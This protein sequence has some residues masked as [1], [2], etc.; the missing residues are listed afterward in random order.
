[1]SQ[2][3][4]LLGDNRQILDSLPA[5]SAD[6]CVCDP[7]Y[8]II[9][10]G[11][12]FAIEGAGKPWETDLTAME[13]E[14]WKKI[15]RVLKPGAHL[16]AFCG[17][18]FYHLMG[19]AIHTAGFQI[20]DQIDWIYA[21]GMPRNKNLFK[22]AHEVIC[23]ARKP[24]KPKQRI[25][26]NTADAAIPRPAHEPG[27]PRWPTNV[28]FSH[29]EGCEKGRCASGCPVGELGDRARFFFV[30]KA[31]AV[32]DKKRDGFVHP[33]VKPLDLMKHLVTLVAQPGM[34][35]LDPWMGSGTTG[36]A[37]RE[38]GRRFI[39][40][41]IDPDYF[42]IAHNRVLGEPPPPPPLESPEMNAVNEALAKLE[43]KE[44]ALERVKKLSAALKA[45]D[46]AIPGICESTADG[47]EGSL[48]CETTA[49]TDALT[50]DDFCF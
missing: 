9:V 10:N 26:L 41:D 3:Q 36:V 13:P 21:E 28:M 2:F 34:T 1:M 49:D 40:I 25:P 29:A 5:D 16:L 31:V 35:V 50:D 6:A 12:Y 45:E 46:D 7:P 38:L 8:G 44:K 11:P 33:T 47:T 19:Y 30:S 37:C 27:K 4:L 42:S 18:R 32:A 48:T 24:C 39:G 20:F 22:P 23:V 15:Y 43:E 17:T 14:V